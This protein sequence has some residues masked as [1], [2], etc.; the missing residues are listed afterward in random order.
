MSQDINNT[1]AE[2]L[3]IKASREDREY[4]FSFPEGVKF[5]EIADVLQQMRDHVVYMGR[6]EEQRMALEKAKEKSEAESMTEA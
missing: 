1:Q 3:I 5:S 2:P 6:I 4:A